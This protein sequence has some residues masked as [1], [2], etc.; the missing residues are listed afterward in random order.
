MLNLFEYLLI[1]PDKF[2]YGLAGI[3]LIIELTVIGLSGPLLFFAIG[4]ALTGILISLG[5]LNSW[6]MEVLS[7]GLMSILT[8]VVLWKPLK[9]FQGSKAVTDSSSDMIGKVVPV[10]VTIT[11]DTGT[12]RHS[13]INWT[14]RLAS[15]CKQNSIES[16]EKVLITGVDGN[17]VL[18]NS[19]TS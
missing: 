15:S 1:N 11:I 14:A 16:G 12:I 7:V 17:I 4:C 13:G 5:I 19:I 9:H 2:L 8:A 18:V 3:S 10:S 6:E